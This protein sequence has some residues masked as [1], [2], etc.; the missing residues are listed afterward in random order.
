MTE[1]RTIDLFSGAGGSS[2]GARLAGAK[3]VAGFDAWNR[4]ACAYQENFPE[5][6]VFEG[7]LESINPTAVKRRVGP[8]DLLLASPECRHHSLARGAGRRTVESRETAYQVLRFASVFRPR[9]LIIENVVSMR[10]WSRYRTFQRELQGLGYHVREQVINAADFGVPQRRKRLFLLCDRGGLP[11]A[12]KTT[13]RPHIPVSQV[14]QF[15][16]LYPVSPL[17]TPRRAIATLERAHRATAALGPA[18]SYLLVYY[19]SDKAGGWQPLSQTLRTIT[20]LDRFALVQ[21]AGNG[22]SMRMLQVPE[23]KRA[24]GIPQVFSLGD[25]PRREKIHLL[26]NAVCPPVMRAVVRSLCR[27]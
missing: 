19:S 2:W 5:A 15:D 3:I 1:L 27:R 9:S 11:G 20:T 25:G 26:G 7:R 16:A 4:A 18:T 24:M 17:V 8:I 13:G 10:S 22:Y 23:L 14:L 12:V 21:P 6:E